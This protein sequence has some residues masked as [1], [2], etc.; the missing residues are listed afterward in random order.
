MFFL[1]VSVPALLNVA[2][3]PH[4]MWDSDRVLGVF[5]LEPLNAY[6]LGIH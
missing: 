3:L 4:R 6:A 2:L 1:S 5:S